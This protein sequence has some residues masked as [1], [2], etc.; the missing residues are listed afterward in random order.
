MCERTPSGRIMR[1]APPAFLPGHM[2]ILYRSRRS[3]LLSSQYNTSGAT[4]P[5]PSVQ[6][7]SI[8]FLMASQALPSV[9]AAPRTTTTT[10]TPLNVS[11]ALPSLHVISQASDD[12]FCDTSG[13]H[14]SSVVRLGSPQPGIQLVHDLGAACSGADSIATSSINV[15]WGPD[16]NSWT[17]TGVSLV[18]TASVLPSTSC[19][20]STS[21]D[22]LGT[23]EPGTMAWWT[24]AGPMTPL[25]AG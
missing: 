17:L 21:R 25:S 3:W 20:S 23:R 11:P 22:A 19:R 14:P 7:F 10:L 18:L 1:K 16:N 6:H 12:S 24:A 8:A 9:S 13:S 15:W 2:W 4:Q 5:D